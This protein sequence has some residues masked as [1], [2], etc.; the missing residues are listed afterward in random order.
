MN[1][2]FKVKN[3]E[4]KNKIR[5][6]NVKASGVVKSNKFFP[7]YQID[8]KEF[9]FKPLSKTKPLTTGLFSYAEV[10][11]SN[12]IKKYFCEV[13]IYNLAICN[14]YEK[15][16]PKYY[17]KGCL[18]QNILNEDE[19]LVNLYE[20]FLVNKDKAV[21]I[22]E[23]INYCLKAYDYTCIFESDLFISNRK[24]AEDL[25][26]QVLI[27][28]LKCDQNFHYENIAFICKNNEIIRMAPMLDH[29]FST[30]FLF[31]EDEKKNFK[32]FCDFVD[33]TIKSGVNFNN[34]QFIIKNFPEVT[35]S[36]KIGLLELQ[37]DI[38]N[39]KLENNNFLWECSSYFYEAGIAEFKEYNIEKS[40][41]L[42]KVLKLYSIDIKKIESMVIEEIETMCKIL[43]N[44]I[45]KATS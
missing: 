14:G 34:L 27:S 31:G 39:L 5:S 35:N 7:V 6:L 17:D 37:K 16:E 12:I 4:Y 8:K 36:F 26:M 33:D 25:A 28:I 10:I 29:E 2:D 42:K 9:I 19:Y 32:Y 44:E 18:V 22:D 40:N 13:P 1:I 15:E 38:R 45:E 43:I 30:M 3:V 23:Y 11:W 21:N 41:F 20:Y 24:L